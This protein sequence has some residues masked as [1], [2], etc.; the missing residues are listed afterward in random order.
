VTAIGST[1]DPRKKSANDHESATAPWWKSAVVY[2]IY[3]RSF[4]DSNGDGIGDLRGILD[5]VDYIASLGVDVVW[6]CPIY[7][8]PQDDNGYDISDYRSIDPV[9]GTLEDFD[10][11]LAALH[12]RDIKLIMDLVVNHTSD[13]HPW[14]L[15]SRS[16]L[17]NPK[18][19]WYIW[20]APADEVDPVTGG[21]EPNNWASYFS[22]SAWE[23]D[24]STD[25][26]YLHLFSK[27]QPDLNWENPEVREA[28]YELMNWWLDRGI[29]GFRMDVI[30]FISK[31]QAFP[32][33]PVIIPPWGDGSEYYTAGPRNHEFLQEMH[34]RV[35]AGREDRLL[36]VGEMLGAT[37][38][39]AEL[40]TDRARHELN[41]VFHFEHV[42][43]DQGESKWDV[44]P[45]GLE[46]LKQTVDRWQ[47]GLADRGWNSLYWNNHDQPRAVSRFGDERHRIASAKL[48]GAVIQL[49][50]GTPF[51]YQGEELGMTNAGFASIDEMRDIESVNHFRDATAAGADGGTVLAAINTMSRDNARTP[52]H[53]TAEAHAGF[54]D[55]EPWLRVTSN[56]PE[57]NAERALADP[58]SVLHFY[59]AL[60]RLRHEEPV[61][62]HGDFHM[63][64]RDHEQLFA[65][66]RSYR[67][68]TLV[69]MANMSDGLA[70]IPDASLVK[71]ELI[72]D[73]GVSPAS[74]AKLDLAPWEVRVYCSTGAPE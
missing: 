1:I 66:R 8:S 29:D 70:T 25:E 32:D 17:E 58:D 62:A 44:R 30:N 11:L 48:L 54:T 12:A 60:I 15:E 74:G 33:G 24:Q 3:P 20:R 55:G 19:D 21:R 10:E 22:G 7:R 61:V 69:V 64:L 71:G 36:T 65:Y 37:V 6:L 63:E 47:R 16:S 56:Y 27:K 57:I 43:L 13:E 40:F 28:V 18:R 49:Q 38:E 14:F 45:L 34:A 59:R 72:L 9:F 23:L 35:F 52:M 4:A 53:W 68:T 42:M 50:R 5:K 26:Y 51:M 39:Q 41:M 31:D 67:G 2:Q 73:N 46:A